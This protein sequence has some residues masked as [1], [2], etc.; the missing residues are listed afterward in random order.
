MMMMMILMLLLLVRMM[1]MMMMTMV[2]FIQRCSPLS[3][4]LNALMSHVILNE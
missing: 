3:S 4:R 1:M 2:A